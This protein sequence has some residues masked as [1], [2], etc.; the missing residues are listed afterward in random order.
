MIIKH[1]EQNCPDKTKFSM[2]IPVL[3]T[4]PGDI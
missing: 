1:I 2:K 3:A 4:E